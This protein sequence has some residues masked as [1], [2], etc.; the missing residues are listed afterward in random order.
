MIVSLYGRQRA[1]ASKGDRQ[2]SSFPDIC[3]TDEMCTSS[4][5]VKGADSC[6]GCSVYLG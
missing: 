1:A 3:I 6:S 4:M 5:R 2:Y